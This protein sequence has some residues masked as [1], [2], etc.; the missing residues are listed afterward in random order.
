M[1]VQACAPK[2]WRD[3][4]RQIPRAPWP[5]LPTKSVFSRFNKKRDPASNKTRW[6]VTEKETKVDLCPPYV[7]SHACKCNHIHV[8]FP[9][10]KYAHTQHRH[11]HAYTDTTFQSSSQIILLSL[12]SQ[13][14]L[15]PHSKLCLSLS[16]SPGT[17]H[18][19]LSLGLLLPTPRLFLP[20]TLILCYPVFSQQP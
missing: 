18:Y 14:Y 10:H 8:C 4:S 20:S 7:W 1:V 9:T 16:L 17:W 3:E 5:T 15:L 19:H 13:H 11:T 6:L 2:H 12:P